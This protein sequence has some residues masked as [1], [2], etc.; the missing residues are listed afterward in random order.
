[1]SDCFGRAQ[2]NQTTNLDTYATLDK[3]GY[4]GV[5]AIGEVWAEMLYTVSVNLIKKHGF[6]KDLWPPLPGKDDKAGFYN[7][8]Y[9][10]TKVPKHGN[11]LIF[12]LVLDGMKLQPCRPSFADARDAILA[13]DKAL[14]GGDNACEI[15]NGFAARGLGPDAKLVGGTPWGGGLHKA[16]TSVPAKCRTKKIA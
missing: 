11:T 3:G 6:S 5:H 16:D 1:M 12:Q 14:T 8:N 2:T 9:T 10:K 15:W 4:W 7:D 13:A